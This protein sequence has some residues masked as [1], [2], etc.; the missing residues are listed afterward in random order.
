MQRNRTQAEE[1]FEDWYYLAVNSGIK[2]LIKF[3]QKLWAYREY[4][5]NYFDHL[6]SDARIEGIN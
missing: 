2:Q 1:Y 3:A 4:I 5:L 6:I